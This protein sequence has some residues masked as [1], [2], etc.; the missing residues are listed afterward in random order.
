[1]AHNDQRRQKKLEAKRIKR[2]QQLRDIARLRSGGIGERMLL[3][4]RWPITESRVSDSIW[5]E[6]IGYAVLVRRGPSG[7]TAMSL[8]LLDG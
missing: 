5:E 7:T 6:G 4:C 1:M 2:N 8:F 3:G